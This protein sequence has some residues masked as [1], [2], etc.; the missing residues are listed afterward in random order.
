MS[1]LDP[2]PLQPFLTKLTSRSTLDTDGQRAILAL[3]AHPAQIKTNRDFVRLGERVDHSCFVVEGLIAR[4]GQN[5]EGSRQI[6][7]VHIPT[8]MIDLHSVVSGWA[9]SVAATRSEPSISTG[10]GSTRTSSTGSAAAA[11]TS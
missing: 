6:T 1:L 8:D 5:R 10:S 4:F 2:S 7:A 11:S 3:P 9:T